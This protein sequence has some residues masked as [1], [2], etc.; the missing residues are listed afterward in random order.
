MLERRSAFAPKK[1]RDAL[2]HA[3]GDKCQICGAVHNLQVDHRIPYEVA[4][5]P[6]LDEE[7]PYQILDG[8]C[9]RKKSWDC[10]R[11]QNRLEIK[12]PAICRL[13]IGPNP[14]RT[15]TS[16]C[17]NNGGLTSCGSVMK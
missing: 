15:V 17:S 1:K 12:D 11:C 16:P 6:G 3:A 5:E 7:E 14:Q 13:A 8:S 2:I 10:E 4:G 9:N